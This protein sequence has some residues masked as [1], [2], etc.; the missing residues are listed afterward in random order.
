M[1]YRLLQRRPG[2]REEFSLKPL[3]GNMT[4]S[5]IIAFSSTVWVVIT[6]SDKLIL[7]KLLHLTEFGIFS[8]AAVA[9]SAI[10]SASAP[11]GQAFLPR[12]TKLAA[13]RD[14]NGINALYSRGTQAVCVIVAPAVAILYFF[15]EPILLAWTGKPEIAHQGAPI[16]CLYAIGNGWVALCSFPFYLQYARGDLRLH[17][18]GNI[19][20]LIILVPLFI[21][22]AEHYGAVGTGAVWAAVNGIYVLGWVPVVHA[23]FYK[24]QHLRWMVN[25]IAAI[26]VPTLLVGW[27]LAT[28][29]PWPSGRWAMVAVIAGLGSVLLVVAGGAS[30]MIRNK[31]VHL[32]AHSF[33]WLSKERL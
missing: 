15:A 1:T 29:V 33:A 20:S 16:L 22:A 19:A 24:G 30:S 4:F 14:D 7:S 32:L 9:A 26:V 25:D 17:L 5:L 11:F 21:L 23:K 28:F 8:F 27:L 2:P 6:Q 12:L 3:L 13:E 31:A 10:T 18:I